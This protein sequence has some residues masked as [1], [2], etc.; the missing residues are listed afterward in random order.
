MVFFG[1]RIGCQLKG[2]DDL[3]PLCVSARS[4]LTE[5]FLYFKIQ[6]ICY[7]RVQLQKTRYYISVILDFPIDWHRLEILWANHLV[8][9][10][11][12][13]NLHLQIP[14]CRP[15]PAQTVALGRGARI[16]GVGGEAGGG[17]ASWVEVYGEWDLVA[18]G[19]RE[20]VQ[21]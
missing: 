7:R 9:Q 3:V 6:R 12:V 10:T 5:L 14:L 16:E 18:G 19:G 4:L 20:E 13:L 17:V 11:G 2:V 15:T 21:D 1:E 8:M